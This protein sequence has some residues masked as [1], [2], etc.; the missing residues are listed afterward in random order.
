VNSLDARA[1]GTRHVHV[2]WR[3]EMVVN[4][5]LAIN[6]GKEVPIALEENRFEMWDGHR[7]KVPS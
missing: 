3:N 6:L 7:S 4:F 5:D 2:G 1:S